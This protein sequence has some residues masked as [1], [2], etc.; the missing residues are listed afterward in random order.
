MKKWRK[1]L[2]TMMLIFCMGGMLYAYTKTDA[3]IRKEITVAEG[4]TLNLVISCYDPDGDV[5]TLNVED[6]PSG[7]T[8][9]PAQLEVQ[10]YGDSDLPP[11]PADSTP[12]WY[13][14]TITWTPTYHQ[15]GD[16]TIAVQAVDSE[17]GVE[18]M[19][20]IIHVTNT[21]R[22]PVL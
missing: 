16:Y 17:G 19:K 22:P 4:T 12:A 13:T 11:P 8:A 2:I 7:A 21:N 5:V 14:T 9:S 20:Y 10:G 1:I 15:S 18:W 6:L 3:P